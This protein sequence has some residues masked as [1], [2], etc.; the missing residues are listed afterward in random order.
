MGVIQFRCDD[1]LQARFEAAAKSAGMTPSELGRAILERT[2]P[3]LK[4]EDPEERET[5]GGERQSESPTERVYARLTPSEYA[6]MKTRAKAMGMTPYTW[7]MRLI[8]AHLTQTPQLNYDEVFALRKASRELS[9]VG[10]GLR[11]LTEVMQMNGHQHHKM[12]VLAV[13]QAGALIDVTCDQIKASLDGN[14]YR[15]VGK[16]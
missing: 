16:P 14:L 9:Y 5:D 8:R 12:A 4:A 2:L 15:W 7:I 6:A 1:E 13:A 11:R 3:A 10:R